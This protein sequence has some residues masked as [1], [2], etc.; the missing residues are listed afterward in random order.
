MFNKV[1]NCVGPNITAED[2]GVKVR[3]A[4]ANYVYDF[5]V[6]PVTRGSLGYGSYHKD[7]IQGHPGQRYATGEAFGLCSRFVFRAVLSLDL[8]TQTVLLYYMSVKYPSF[9]E[10]FRM[11]FRVQ[12]TPWLLW[13]T[14]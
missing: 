7:I 5:H 12:V 3:G 2:F 13:Q 1:R 6:K 10:L 8:I 11:F 9:D 4:P 14:D